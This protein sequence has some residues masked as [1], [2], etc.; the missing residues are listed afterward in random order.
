MSTLF[1]FFNVVFSNPVKTV[2]DLN[3][4]SFGIGKSQLSLNPGETIELLTYNLSTSGSS[5]TL[6]H[7]WVT[8]T[9]ISAGWPPTTNVSIS[10]YVQWSF[11]IDGESTPSISVQTSQA[12]LIGGASP[13]A[14]WGHDFAGKNSLF[15]GWH[16]NIPIPF[17]K[18]IVI[19]ISLPAWL[20]AKSHTL[21]AQARGVENIPATVGSFTLPPTARLG[22]QV[23]NSTLQVLDFHTLLYLP[24]GT[25]GLMLAAMIDMWLFGPHADQTNSLEGC[26]HFFSPPDAPFPGLLLGTGAED[27]PESAYYFNA[28]KYLGPTSGLSVWDIQ[29]PTL[30]HVSFY[31]LHHRDPIFFRDGALFKWVRFSA[32]QLFPLPSLLSPSCPLLVLT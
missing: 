16:I 23:V 18:S 9:P 19:T 20:P 28:G 26:W 31:K 29:S 27:Y 2:D 22:A 24:K 7:F 25:K 13:H 15:G 3:P 10:D 8:G 12:A 5:G 21:F 14:P 1:L 17:Q 11:Y 4:L 30:S 6:T 32:S